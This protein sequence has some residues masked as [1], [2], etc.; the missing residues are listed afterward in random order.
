MQKVQKQSSPGK[1]FLAIVLLVTLSCWRLL[2]GDSWWVLTV[3]DTNF[4][5]QKSKFVTNI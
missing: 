2:V 1:D 3:L 5:R 4:K